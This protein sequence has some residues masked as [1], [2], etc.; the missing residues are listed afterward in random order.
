[1]P[2]EQA[3]LYGS[4]ARNDAN[5]NSDIDVLLVSDKI[6]GDNLE[7]VGKIYR[8]AYPIDPRIEPYLVSKKRFLDQNVYS[9]VIDAVRREGIEIKA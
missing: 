3:F 6:S 7:A 9:T 2:V 8:L 5:E 4:Y 1:M